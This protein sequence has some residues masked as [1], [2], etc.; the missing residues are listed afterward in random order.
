MVA[1]TH[2][3]SIMHS[4]V[5]DGALVS[6]SR[7]NGCGFGSPWGLDTLPPSEWLPVAAPP[8][9][10]AAELHMLGHNSPGMFVRAVSSTHFPF[11]A[12]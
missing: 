4:Q 7:L 9:F 10:V 8:A 12:K 5:L 1:C 11:E 2:K 3:C 6:A